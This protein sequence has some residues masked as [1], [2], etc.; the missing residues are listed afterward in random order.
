[1]S[2]HEWIQTFLGWQAE[3]AGRTDFAATGGRSANM[4]DVATCEWIW[5]S[6]G[7]PGFGHEPTGQLKKDVVLAMG[8]ARK[9][10][11]PP[12]SLHGNMNKILSSKHLANIVPDVLSETEIFYAPW[13]GYYDMWRDVPGSSVI[14]MRLFAQIASGAAIDWDQ[15][16]TDVR[17]GEH[18]VGNTYDS[19]AEILETMTSRG[20][21]AELTLVGASVEVAYENWRSRWSSEWYSL[22][23]EDWRTVCGFDAHTYALWLHLNS[24][25]ISPEECST[26]ML[27][28]RALHDSLDYGSDVM[29]GEWANTVK[30]ATTVC[31]RG[32]ICGYTLPYLIRE[33]L[34]A[35]HSFGLIAD[36]L[37]RYMCAEL[38]WHCT[39]PRYHMFARV[40]YLLLARLPKESDALLTSSAAQACRWR[41]YGHGT[42]SVEGPI[43][44]AAFERPTISCPDGNMVDR[45]SYLQPVRPG[46]CCAAR[47]DAAY[48]LIAEDCGHVH[49]SGFSLLIDISA[50]TRLIFDGAMCENCAFSAAQHLQIELCRNAARICRG[51]VLTRKSE[52]D[53]WTRVLFLEKGSIFR[54]LTRC[55]DEVGALETHRE[56]GFEDFPCWSDACWSDVSNRTPTEAVALA[57]AEPSSSERLWAK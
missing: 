44:R 40:A 41:P 4:F 15:Q 16:L 7:I 55:I 10:P 51:G 43:I 8:R 18:F 19:V 50:F 27:L 13:G 47:I 46:Q 12:S 56:N 11:P 42:A 21:D 39:M 9:V 35:R 57:V 52:F 36:T 45:Y 30:I 20:F 25:G 14:D 48:K 49:A 31:E 54:Q 1:M 5:N 24:L 28:G 23:Y 33:D 34:K 32:A 2:T 29:H 26:W 3:H 37:D 17:L 53:W 38:L 6:L 22:S